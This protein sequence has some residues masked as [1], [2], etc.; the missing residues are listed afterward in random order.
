[1]DSDY[2]PKVKALQAR[3]DSFM[4]EHIYRSRNNTEEQIDSHRRSPPALMHELK[5]SACAAPLRSRY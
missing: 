3:V 5:R 4:N 1:M 2:S